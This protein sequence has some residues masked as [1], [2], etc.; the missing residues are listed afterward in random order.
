MTIIATRMLTLRDDGTESD[1]SVCLHAPEKDESGSWFC[2]YEIEWPDKKSDMA[3]WGY[4]SV[5]TL[6]LA[7]QTIGAEIYA[8]SYHMSGNLMLDEPGK[9]YGFPVMPTL[10]DLLQGDDVKYL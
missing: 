5:Q 3:I 6:V 7:L 4:D 2:R 10:R 8:S 9:G 1:I